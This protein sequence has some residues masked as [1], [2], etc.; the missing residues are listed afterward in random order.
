VAGAHSDDELAA[1]DLRRLF[2]AGISDGA[3]PVRPELQGHGA[4]AAAV[5][6]E[7]SGVSMAHVTSAIERVRE[8]LAGRTPEPAPTPP[9]LRDLVT[10]GLD[11]GRDQREH[12]LFVRWLGQVLSLMA[13][14]ARVGAA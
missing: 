8:L 9:F 5:Q 3:G 2:E 4:V 6:L 13:V 7:R 12:E 14:R 11:V 1:L 10:W